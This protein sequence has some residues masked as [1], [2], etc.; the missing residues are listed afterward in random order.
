MN[1]M[2]YDENANYMNKKLAFFIVCAAKDLC[3]AII[4]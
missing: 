4:K 3:K 2:L 1:D